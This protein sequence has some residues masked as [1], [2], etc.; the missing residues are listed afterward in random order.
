MSRFGDI[1]GC[2]DLKDEGGEDLLGGD[3]STKIVEL[4]VGVLR[5]LCV[6]VGHNRLFQPPRL[7]VFRG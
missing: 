4:L 5:E 7:L 3:V 2:P 6:K 1:D